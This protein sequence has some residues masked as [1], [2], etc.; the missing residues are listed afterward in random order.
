MCH[1]ALFN[2]KS[3]GEGL[4]KERGK[5]HIPSP[6]IHPHTNQTSAKFKAGL[7]LT[8]TIPSQGNVQATLGTNLLIS[9]F[10]TIK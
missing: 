4:Q 6:K 7:C 9:D 10:S 5:I 3:T 1:H 8:E 2:L